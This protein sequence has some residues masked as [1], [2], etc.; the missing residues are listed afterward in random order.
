MLSTEAVPLMSDA[1][2]S[3]NNDNNP[4]LEKNTARRRGDRGGQRQVVMNFIYTP[5]GHCLCKSS[6][7]LLRAKK[8]YNEGTLPPRRVPPPLT[9]GRFLA[10]GGL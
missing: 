4:F 3:N 2:V 5:K 9:S 7:I 6:F 10:K 8:I 1:S